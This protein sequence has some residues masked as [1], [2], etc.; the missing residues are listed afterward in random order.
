M[1]NTS[2]I[3]PPS[4]R[5]PASEI[6][7][8]YQ[9]DRAGQ[10]RA[11]SWFAPFILSAKD[12]DEYGDAQLM[13]Q[14]I[15]ACLAVITSDTDGTGGAARHGRRHADAGRYAR[16]R[17]D[18][19]VPPGRSVTVVDPPRIN[20]YERSCGSNCGRSRRASA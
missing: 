3:F 12:L 15:A 11:V 8:V 13:K 18:L 17:R 14:K 16:A 10:V 2:T 9:R 7:H 4:R 5:I 1:L 6:L 20:E 19:N